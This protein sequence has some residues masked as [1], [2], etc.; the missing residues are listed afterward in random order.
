VLPSFVGAMRWS[1]GRRDRHAV[2]QRM[3]CAVQLH[4]RRARYRCRLHPDAHPYL[5]LPTVAGLKRSTSPSKNEALMRFDHYLPIVIPS[6]LSGA[7]LV[8]IRH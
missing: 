8:L 3:G 7:L 6:V 4:L 2:P 1:F 5:L